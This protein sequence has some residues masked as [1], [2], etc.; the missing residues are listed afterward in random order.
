MTIII[1]D[2]TI[3]LH[4]GFYLQALNMKDTETWISPEVAEEI[5]SV[6]PRFALDN[7]IRENWVKLKAA[8][9]RA[10]E[11]A[12]SAAGKTGDLPQLSDQDLTVIALALDAREIEDDSS[13]VYTDDYSIQNV[14]KSAG[15]KFKATTN[16]G[17]TKVIKWVY[18][19]MACKARFKKPLD[20]ADCP[21]CG[22]PGL[23]KKT[24]A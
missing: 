5:R 2:A 9:P 15:I 13:L 16:Q 6:L 8:S 22:T 3:F 14:L 4:G 1:V 10:L 24:R 23:V 19:C 21:E 12:K 20:D 11:L 17:I 7:A 18:T